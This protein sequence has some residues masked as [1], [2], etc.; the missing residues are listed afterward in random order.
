MP[1]VFVVPAMLHET[2]AIGRAQY[3]DLVP[4]NVAGARD[5]EFD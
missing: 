5:E 3:G 1:V 2:L 4:R